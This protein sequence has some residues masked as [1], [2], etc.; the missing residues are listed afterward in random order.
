[1]NYLFLA[2]VLVVAGDEQAKSATTSDNKLIPELKVFE[3]LVGKTYRGEFADSTPEKPNRDVSQWERALNG[4]G[5][6][7][8]H[9]VNDGEYGGET[10]VM[11][12]AKEK[13]IAFWYFTTAGFYTTGHFDIDGDTWTSSEKVAGNQNGITEVKATS[14]IS[15]DGTLQV[16]SQYLQNGNWVKGH[17]IKYTPATDAKVIFK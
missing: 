9:S 2:F 16:S 12:D 6:R 1:M 11:W 13:K 10:M 4:R 15:A 3:P 7:I 14:I 5:V 17:E 8:L